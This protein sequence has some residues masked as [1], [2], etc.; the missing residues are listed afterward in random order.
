MPPITVL[1]VDDQE[2]FRRAV[3]QLLD[4]TDGFEEVGEAAS[5]P[6]AV[7]AAA[8]LRP[9]LILLDVRMPRMDGIETHRRLAR[10]SPGSLV[11][12][13][14]IEA[15]VDLPEAVTEALHVR[16]QD[17]SPVVLREIW[18]AQGAPH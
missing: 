2:I 10:V 1:V 12:L 9:D 4:A 6:E 8:E 5:G 14:S 3:R 11:V 7:A 15:G 18:A 17:L 16:K 13:I